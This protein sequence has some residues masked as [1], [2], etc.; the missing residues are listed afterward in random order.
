VSGIRRSHS[1]HQRAAAPHS[2]ITSLQPPPRHGQKSKRS[3]VLR[4][5]HQHGIYH[6]HGVAPFPDMNGPQRLS[7]I[8]LLAFSYCTGRAAQ[9]RSIDRSQPIEIIGIFLHPVRPSEE[10]HRLHAIDRARSRLQRATDRAQLVPG[11]CREMVGTSCSGS[12]AKRSVAS[13]QAASSG[14]ATCW[15]G[16]PNAQPRHQDLRCANLSA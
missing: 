3:E 13:I 2:R 1:S 6:S 5:I 9:A 10:G 4:A 11:G 14:C 7:Y 15:E 16:F 8:V 12:S